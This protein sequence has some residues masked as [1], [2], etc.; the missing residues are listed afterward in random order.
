MTNKKLCDDLAPN[1]EIQPANFNSPGQVVI[2]G[3]NE[4]IDKAIENA[5]TYGAKKGVKLNVSAPFHSVYMK[6]AAEKLKEEFEKI[7]WNEAKFDIIANVSARPVKLSSDFQ[8]CFMATKRLLHG[9]HF[10]N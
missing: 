8:P 5:K 2:S 1:G 7:S 10:R 4:F 3:L 6:P 9:R